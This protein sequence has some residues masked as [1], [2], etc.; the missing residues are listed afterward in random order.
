MR[1]LTRLRFALIGL[2]IS[3]ILIRMNV[4]WQWFSQFEWQNS[5][6]TRW[7]WQI[8]GLVLSGLFSVLCWG[9]QRKWIKLG[10]LPGPIHE[11]KKLSSFR[12]LFAL[13]ISL[14]LISAVIFCFT[15]LA[16]VALFNPFSLGIWWSQ[17]F[18]I[19][20]AGS[21]P[22]F[23][24]LALIFLLV[25]YKR[26]IRIIQLIGS[27]FFCLVVARAWG[28]WA[29][30]LSIPQSGFSEP[31]FNADVAFGLGRY[32]ALTLG[33]L[34]VFLLLILTATTSYWIQLTAFNR[35]SDWSAPHL[36]ITQKNLLR[37]ISFLIVLCGSSLL[38]LSRHNFL[39]TQNDSFPGAGWLDVHFNVPLRTAS[40]LFLIVFAF[41]LIPLHFIPY[42]RYLRRISFLLS[43]GSIFLE[44]SLTPVLQWILVRPR[45]LS[46]ETP[47]LERAIK[48]TRKAF[49]LDSIKTRLINPRS[50][51]TKEDLELGA[52]T[53]A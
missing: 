8:S 52:S 49:Q 30:G 6:L 22:L 34:L 28:I 27:L 35:L 50:Q 26:L 51:L 16:L 47:Y 18:S 13:T 4:E 43:I 15:K 11:D 41:L 23:T 38:W 19:Q 42:R 31:L 14:F 7:L 33:F 5:L 20:E 46:Y 39:W 9:W 1:T 25:K 36:T 40:S 3:W 37:P 17:I 53:T 10:N 48:A 32:P 29:L 21:L 24:L 45:E 12:Y 44:F 2:A